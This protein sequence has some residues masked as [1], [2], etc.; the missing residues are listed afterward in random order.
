MTAFSDRSIA[1]RNRYAGVGT[2]D[3]RAARERA[4]LRDAICEVLGHAALTRDEI[5]AA[6][7]EDWGACSDAQVRSAL[8]ALH[9]AGELRIVGGRY[10]ID[11]GGDE[12]VG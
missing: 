9:G 7:R 8:T 10:A 3:E 2:T 5:A 6:V 1:W 4:S 12:E 11:G